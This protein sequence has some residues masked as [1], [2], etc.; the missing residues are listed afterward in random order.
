MTTDRK[1]RDIILS[2]VERLKRDYQPE[3][4]ILYGSFA[5]GKPNR[6]SDIDLLVIKNTQQRPI[7]RRVTVRRIVSDLR[8]GVPFSSVVVTPQEL[9]KRLEMGD[10]FFEEIVDR[11]KV[12]YAG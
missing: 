10:Q 6:D 4:I 8:H 1:A 7:D 11:G 12:L 3:K 5:Y 9:K 2:I